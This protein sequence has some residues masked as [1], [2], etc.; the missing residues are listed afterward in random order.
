MQPQKHEMKCHKNAQRKKSEILP[1]YTR[2]NNLSKKYPLSYPSY[3][4]LFKKVNPAHNT[5]MD[6]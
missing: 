3:Q 5:H 1:A 2:E 6:L 4:S